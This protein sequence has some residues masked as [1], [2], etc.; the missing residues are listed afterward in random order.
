MKKTLKLTKIFCRIVGHKYK[1]VQNY[2]PLEQQLEC[3]NCKKAVLKQ[4]NGQ[5]VPFSSQVREAYTQLEKYRI[6][7]LKKEKAVI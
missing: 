4:E 6:K 3:N 5:L 2:Q 1:V 7:K